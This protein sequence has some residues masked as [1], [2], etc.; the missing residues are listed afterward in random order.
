[1]KH[2]FYLT[3][4][5]RIIRITHR[6]KPASYNI[7]MIGSKKFP[8][9]EFNVLLGKWSPRVNE[10]EIEFSDLDRMHYLG[11]VDTN[12]VRAENMVNRLLTEQT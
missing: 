11:W 10:S 12:S 3:P 1:M 9:F 6:A 7:P 8:V 5:E 2:H 4:D